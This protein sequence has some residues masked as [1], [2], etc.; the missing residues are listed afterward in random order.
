VALTH[1]CQPPAAQHWSE[2]IVAAR[3]RR[4]ARTI[5]CSSAAQMTSALEK[6]YNLNGFEMLMPSESTAAPVLSGSEH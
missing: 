6:H 3:L 1:W 2:V 4:D 5:A